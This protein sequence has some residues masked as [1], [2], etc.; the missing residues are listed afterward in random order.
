MP[1]LIADRLHRRESLGI[2]DPFLEGF[3]HLF[4]I[5]PVGRR[6]ADQLA[7][8]D[9]DAAPFADQRDEVRFLTVRKSTQALGAN[10]PPVR[11][12]L[13]EDELLFAVIPAAHDR[14]SELIAED[15]VAVE[16]FLY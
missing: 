11:E 2:R 13:V 1:I 8:S 7:V 5:E 3:D 12:E 4:V 15:F 9:G 6:V 16:G 14:L 10:G